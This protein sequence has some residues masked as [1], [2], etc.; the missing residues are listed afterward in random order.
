MMN[1]GKKQKNTGRRAFPIRLFLLPFL[2]VVSDAI[3]IALLLEGPAAPAAKW[4]GITVVLLIH[5]AVLYYI[6]RH[7][8]IPIEH[9][10]A[11]ILA[12]GNTDSFD[13]SGSAEK[14]FDR[15]IKA[16]GS[17]AT[18]KMLVTQAEI[19]A[20]QNQINP[21]F[22]YN[23]L[24]AIRCHAIAHRM[25]EIAEM[26]EALA[27]LFR[28]GINR[29]GKMAT[30]AEE[31]DN[32]RN[33]LTIQK[34]RFAD[35]ISVAW[36]VEDEDANIMECPLPILTIQP[37]VENAIH[38]GL[39]TKMGNGVISIRAYTTQTKLIISVTDDGIGIPEQKLDEILH[40][41]Y[42][43]SNLSSML[44]KDPN[45]VSGIALINVNQRLKFYFGEEYGLN[46]ESTVGC[47]TSVE[48][49]MPR[50]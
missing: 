29:P 42:E 23:T 26:T 14:V 45:F 1:K 2:I 30:L 25:P 8:L 16:I 36:F 33:Y 15:L 20:L 10:N 49:I 4:S 6:I 21:H 22:L 46:I 32:V 48:I 41:L 35:K 31:L 11:K 47:G 50:T 37:I 28:Y 39:E 9:L 3:L 5:F 13:L 24:E 12:L 43:T 27:T 19:R 7:I 34:Y 44:T 18:A 38:H 40:A 17:E